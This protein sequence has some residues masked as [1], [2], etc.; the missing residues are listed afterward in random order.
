[1][2]GHQVPPCRYQLSVPLGTIV[3]LQRLNDVLATGDQTECTGEPLNTA[4]IYQTEI[5]GEGIQ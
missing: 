5:E 3:S 1:M 2:P 4:E